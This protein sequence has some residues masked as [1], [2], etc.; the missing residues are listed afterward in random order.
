MSLNQKI[1]FYGLLVNDGIIQELLLLLLA[2]FRVIGWLPDIKKH[3]TS[4]CFLELHRKKD[5]GIFFLFAVSSAHVF[6]ASQL[7]LCAK[8]GLL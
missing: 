7:P 5:A 8:S 2:F 4:Q 6:V 1:L 3:W